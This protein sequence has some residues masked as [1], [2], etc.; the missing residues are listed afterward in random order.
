MTVYFSCPKKRPIVRAL[1]GDSTITRD[2]PLLRLDFDTLV[3][4]FTALLWVFLVFVPLAALLFL[5][6]GLA[7][8]M[9]GFSSPSCAGV[10]PS[11]YIFVPQTEQVP[12]VTAPPRELK[13]ASGLRI[14]LFSLH[15]KQ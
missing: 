14:S 6:L 4:D 15:L 5:D 11:R 3:F 10:F 1:A 9:T 12:V 7:L 2:F 8:V 13:P